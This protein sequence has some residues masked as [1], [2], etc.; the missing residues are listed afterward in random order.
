MKIDN[1]EIYR[2]WKKW[3]ASSPIVEERQPSERFGELMLEIAKNLL[4]SPR[5]VGYGW[6]DKEEMVGDAVLKMM[7]NLKNIREEKKNSLFSYLTLCADC[8]YATFLRRKNRRMKFME[9]YKADVTQQR[10]V[11]EVR[12][13]VCR[14]LDD[15]YKRYIEGDFD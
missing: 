8:A 3:E 1:D 13:E 9:D 14:T 2:E 6:E 12:H 7:K 10:R 5:Y 15:D 4:L 11:H